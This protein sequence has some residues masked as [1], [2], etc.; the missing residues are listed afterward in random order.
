MIRFFQVAFAASSMLASLASARFDFENVHSHQTQGLISG[1]GSPVVSVV[2]RP[3]GRRV[4]KIEAEAEQRL[5]EKEL[6][7]MTALAREMQTVLNT[8]QWSPPEWQGLNIAVL[9]RN[10]R[11]FEKALKDIAEAASEEKRRIIRDLAASNIADCPECRAIPPR[12]S[13]GASEEEA[14]TVETPTDEVPPEEDVPSVPDDEGT[15][16]VPERTPGPAEEVPPEEAEPQE[17]EG[18][19]EAPEQRPS[20]GT[21][22]PLPSSEEVPP[23]SADEAPEE[24]TAQEEIPQPTVPEPS[25]IKGPVTPELTPQ[26]KVCSEG[27]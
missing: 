25:P 23:A 5:L 16:D 2:R 4:W 26:E 12:E 22:A 21:Q 15:E 3:G 11:D 19:K 7:K 13:G 17:N 8:A 10:Q 20:T 18:T 14:S 9:M 6:G 1:T 27:L 24:P